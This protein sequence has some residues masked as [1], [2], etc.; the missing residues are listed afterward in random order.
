MLRLASGVAMLSTLW[1]LAGAAVAQGETLPKSIV[2]AGKT[3]TLQAP[4]KCPAV[5]RPRKELARY[6]NQYDPS[7]DPREDIRDETPWTKQE[8]QSIRN[9]LVEAGFHYPGGQDSVLTWMDFDA[10]GICD[11]T[12]SAGIGGMRSQDRM[13]LFRGLPTGEFRLADAYATYMEGSSIVVPYIPIAVS[14]EKT[15]I[16][17]GKSTLVQWQSAQNKLASCESITYGPQAAKERAAA[18][19]LAAL[20]SQVQQIYTW[21]AAQLPH[22]NAIPYSNGK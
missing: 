20:C 3:L 6:L 1:T 2:I 17:A 13:F 22:K 5:Q 16:L 18:P 7:E 8:I 4:M 15:P 19:A 21:A 12:A 9:D 10:D 14:G 11:F